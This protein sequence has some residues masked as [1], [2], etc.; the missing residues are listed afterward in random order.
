MTADISTLIRQARDAESRLDR[1][2]AIEAYQKAQ[3]QDP[4]QREV[5]FRLAYNLDLA[6]EEAEATS[7]LEQVCADGR[8]P[9]NALLNLAI[10][11]EDAGQYAKAER[12]LRLVL[13]TNPNHARARLYLKD[14]QASRQMY[15]EDEP[16]TRQY[17]DPVLNTPVSDF[18]LSA[19][20]RNCLKKM[21]IR[22]LGDLL[23][24]S[25]A[26]LLAYKSFGETTLLEIKSLLSQ[27]GL[28]LGQALDQQRSATRDQVY[29]QVAAQGGEEAVSVL[30]KPVDDLDLSVRARKA[31]SLLNIATIGD[32]IARTEAELLGIKNFGSTSLQEIKAKLSELGLSLRKLETE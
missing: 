14:V 23:R 30:L 12:C 20:A 13:E 19:R 29:E 8:P 17:S 10:M 7:L 11:Y 2:L 26:E 32:L 6:G 1:A 18:E 28:K 24:I 22:T 5:N 9:L 3:Q 25:E 15:V 21:N 16:R 31:V 27:K 4:G